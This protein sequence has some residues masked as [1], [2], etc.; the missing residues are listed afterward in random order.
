VLE[1]GLVESFVVVGSQGDERL[2]HEESVPIVVLP[3]A[4]PIPA[5]ELNHRVE[6]VRADV[7]NPLCRQLLRRSIFI[8]SLALLDAGFQL[9]AHG[10]RQVFVEALFLFS[11]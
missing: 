7:V 1:E 6:E 3:Y 9:F 11:R 2:D 8:L 10:L 5:E 4:A